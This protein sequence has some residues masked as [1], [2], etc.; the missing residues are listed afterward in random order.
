MRLSIATKVFLGLTAVLV[1]MG[2]V[3]VYGIV[4][5]HRI[6]EGLRFV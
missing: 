6:G 3:S 1:S 5:M 2:L 4:R